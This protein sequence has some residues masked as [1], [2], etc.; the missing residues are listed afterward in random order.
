MSK[1]LD[2]LSQAGGLT[3]Q[4][5]SGA[6]LY[7]YEAG[8]TTT[9]LA[10]YQD[11]DLTPSLA[12]TNPVVADGEG[13]FPD[14]W[15]QPEKYYVEFY[16]ADGNLL[17]AKD[18][19]TGSVIGGRAVVIYDTIAEMTAVLKATI[20]DDQQV[21]VGGYTTVGDGGGGIFYW[22][23]ASTATVDSGT[24]F[25]ADEGGTGRWIRVFTGWVNVKWFGATGDGT[26][27]DQ[28]AVQAAINSFGTSF[29][30]TLFFPS[31]EYL[32][33]SA[34][35]VPR[36]IL[37]L[38]DGIP[39]TA[40]NS[41]T[42]KN[43]SFLVHGFN[44][45][46][47]TFDGSG[48]TG[49]ITGSGG[50]IERLSILNKFGIANSANGRAVVVDGADAT[51]R[52]TW[53]RIVDC[54]ISRYG[55]SYGEFSWSID[56]DGST[57]TA[58]N[59]GIR[60]IYLDRVRIASDTGASGSIRLQTAFNVFMTNIQCNLTKG[61]ILITGSSGAEQS[62]A[63]FGNNLVITGSFDV[64]YADN[65]NISGGRT[66]AISTT[67]NTGTNVNLNFASINSSAGLA[68]NGNVKAYSNTLS[69]FMT[70]VNNAISEVFGRDD[71]AGDSTNG[72]GI[73]VGNTSSDQGGALLQYINGVPATG[74]QKAQ[75]F[76][77]ARNV[78]DTAE[79]NMAS[80]QMNQVATNDWAQ[81]EL[82]TGTDRKILCY[83]Q[84]T[85]RID[86][87]ADMLPATTDAYDVG[88]AGS[89]WDKGYV[90]GLYLTDGVTAPT[91]AAGHAIIYVDTADGDLKIKFGDGTVKTIV[92]DT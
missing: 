40:V 27:D 80:I 12:N 68:T 92:V 16:D 51:E 32:F 86:F 69:K 75:L 34:L 14:I 45:D 63:V 2:I 91:T 77:R 38:G 58:A 15:L 31:G 83:G 9:F 55:S 52:S 60:D 76:L 21:S 22:D 53:L 3:G 26:T 29:S 35:S 70:R 64:D 43:N 54:D 78:A 24:I 42:V 6:S 61:D 67:A 5:L 62:S 19:V 50:G 10:T 25:A 85:D 4:A 84:G 79:A 44:G 56:I 49:V 87:K 28:A 65:I 36:G 82:Y 66:A 7:F 59:G 46:F 72:T 23:S 90:N 1:Y 17:D 41:E 74:S 13:R 11:E 47:I 88:G 39:G 48:V 89:V 18:N 57:V 81:I 73:I 30:G 33:G 20:L 8:P 71:N 37:L